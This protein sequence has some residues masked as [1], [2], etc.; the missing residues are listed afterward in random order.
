[1][2]TSFPKYETSAH[3]A[4]GNQHINI[5]SKSPEK[6]P[7]ISP[8]FV[9]KFF[10]PDVLVCAKNDKNTILIVCPIKKASIGIMY[11]KDKFNL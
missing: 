10:M 4:N 7:I 6:S 8:R 3:G 11:Q 1:L 2:K 5:L 9:G